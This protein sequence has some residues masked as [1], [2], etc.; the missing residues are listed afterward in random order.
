VLSAATEATALPNTT[1]VATFT[2]SDSSD[3]AGDFT[4]T[5]A[6]GDGVTTAGSVVGSNGSFTVQGG[7]TYAD[8]GSDPAVVTLTHTADSAQAT[9]SGTVSVGEADVLA[10]QGTKIKANIHHAFSG[11]VATFS[12]TDT[13][14]VAGD[15]NATI[16]WGDGT[17]TSGT[18][19]GGSGSFAV[20]GTHQYAH[21]GHENVTVTLTDDAPGTATATA[22][23]TANVSSGA[24][25]DFDGD[26]KSD[27]LLQRNPNSAHP[28]VMVELLN[29]TTIASSGTTAETKGWHVVAAGDFNVD[30]DEDIVLQNTDG[31]PQIWLMNGTSVTST[32]TLANPGS[33]W[34]VIAAAD[35]NGD[36]EPD[37]LFQND[38]G[39][40]MIWEMNGTS[41]TSTATLPNP[42]SSWKVI[43]AG[44]FN[45]DGNDDILFQ[46]SD[47]TVT[48]W[49]MNGTS[50]VS[51][52]AVGNPGGSF[53]AIGTGD[54]NGDG[55]SDILFQ[56]N[57]G[58]P[59]IWEM[60][61]TSILA[62][63]TLSNPGADWRAIGT[64]DF[65][66]DG[67][68]DILF[69]KGN[70]TPLIWEMNGT[71]VVSTFTLTSPG[72]QWKLQDDGP[73]GSGQSAAGSQQPTLRASTP[74]AASAALSAPGSYNL[75]SSLPVPV[76][77]TPF[78]LPT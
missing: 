29:G 25:N 71:S 39:T 58:T 43:G 49:L 41:V 67:M 8:E 62:S 32:V 27:L 5:I 7:H 26:A 6:W 2:D 31:T 54:F 12:D 16:N 18:V 74:D 60:N 4:A 45:G 65:N 37:L 69:Q 15:F 47:G 61:G 33:A 75:A 14:N 20:S 51:A 70:G 53:K 22:N 46:N 77:R 72:P 35:F 11:V 55:M 17:T 28:D 73:I 78:S 42:G 48:E 52:V 40:P 3:M 38:N 13:A 59:L 10:G 64:S 56:S 66:G 23:S 76:G 1:T 9:A 34:H 36:G 63:A 21:P 57:N 44:D 30:G 50:I 24:K 19:S 68:A